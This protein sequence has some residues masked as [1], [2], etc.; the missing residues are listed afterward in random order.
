MGVGSAWHWETS[1]IKKTRKAFCVGPEGMK[2]RGGLE[3]QSNQ[4]KTEEGY[5]TRST[6]IAAH[7]KE[8]PVGGGTNY[9]KLK[10][11]TN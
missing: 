4:G 5:R 11:G 9:R 7:K 6:H 2:R 10:S 1:L 3:E 8:G